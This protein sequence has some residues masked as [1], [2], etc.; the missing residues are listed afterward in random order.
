MN[1]DKENKELNLELLTNKFEQNIEEIAKKYDP[2]INQ[3]EDEK[4]AKEATIKTIDRLARIENVS[5]EEAAVAFCYIM[6]SGGYLL[7]VSDRRVIV[8]GHEYTKKSLIAALESINS[9]YKLRRL[10]RSFRNNIIKIS[11][12]NKLQGNLF[13]QYKKENPETLKLDDSTLL[14]HMIYC[15]D[16]NVDNPEAPQEVLKFL[17]Q[18]ETNK[19]KQKKKK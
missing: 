4:Q 6:Q 11:R 9:K 8:G 2:T 10:A 7:S 15:T 12:I 17:S 5:F 1:T 3:K 19:S 14:E 13:S 16:F 18:R